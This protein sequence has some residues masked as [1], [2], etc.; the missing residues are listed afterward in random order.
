MRIEKDHW[1]ATKREVD[2]R[3]CKSVRR[4][5]KNECKQE[6]KTRTRRDGKHGKRSGENGRRNCLHT[7]CL[8]MESKYIYFLY[9]SLDQACVCWQ[10]FFGVKK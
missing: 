3:V 10:A 9:E 5:E 1:M 6:R 2:K 8:T 7:F 4:E